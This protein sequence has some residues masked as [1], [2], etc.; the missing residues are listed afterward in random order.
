MRITES[1]AFIREK[2]KDVH[3]DYCK[4]IEAEVAHIKKKTKWFGIWTGQIKWVVILEKKWPWSRNFKFMTWLWHCRQ[5][6]LGFLKL[7]LDISV[8]LHRIW[9]S[10]TINKG[11][12]DSFEK[13]EKVVFHWNIH[14]HFCTLNRQFSKNH[15]KITKNCTEK[16]NTVLE[17]IWV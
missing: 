14:V 8:Q 13:L 5:M 11:F 16:P 12:L 6:M 10:S 7:N 15:K 3:S 1:L 2:D 17:R 9:F 4:E